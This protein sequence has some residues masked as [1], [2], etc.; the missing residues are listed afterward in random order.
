MAEGV[1][2]VIP[3]EP[4]QETV[5][6]REEGLEAPITEQPVVRPKVREACLPNLSIEVQG[7]QGIISGAHTLA[8]EWLQSPVVTGMAEGCGVGPTEDGRMITQWRERR[9]MDE[10]EEDWSYATAPG[11]TVMDLLREQFGEGGIP[12][13]AFMAEMDARTRSTIM[14]TN[15]SSST[16]TASGRFRLTSPK[17]KP[18]PTRSDLYQ[19]RVGTQGNSRTVDKSRGGTGGSS[20]VP[21]Q[22]LRSAPGAPFSRGPD[23]ITSGAGASTGPSYTTG[24]GPG[25]WPQG[26]VWG[27]PPLNVTF[28]GNPDKLTLLSQT[29]G[30]MDRYGHLYPSQWAMVGAVTAAL[31]GMALEWIADLHTDHARELASV[32]AFLGALRTCFEDLS[33]IWRTEGEVLNI[34]QRGRPV[35]E[36]EN[37][38]E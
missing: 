11:Q 33:R 31:Q 13:C 34:K 20:T 18:E 5:Q 7:P 2:D 36:Y 37:F 22:G 12:G 16:H 29:I 35:A 3:V 9:P 26:S 21:S 1:Q 23:S 10:E 15:S 14:V 24:W 38:E 6:E 32:G 19:G 30:H 28:D 4:D 25:Q 17:L 8:G 27:P